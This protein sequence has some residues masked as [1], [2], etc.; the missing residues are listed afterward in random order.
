M[1]KE[2]TPFQFDI[3]DVLKRFRRIARSRI[4]GVTLSLPF[5]SVGVSPK[6]REKQIARELV[7][8][9]KDR[10]V[11]N[12][13]ECCDNCINEALTS[14]Q[15]IRAHLVDK[16]VELSELQ[17]GPLYLLI[18]AM[19]LGIRQFLTFEQRLTQRTVVPPGGA[20]NSDFYRAPEIRQAY[21]D[22]LEIL[23]GHLSRCLGQVA[24]LAGMNAPANGLIPNYQ[25][26]WQTE[27]YRPLKLP[28]R[29]S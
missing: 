18:D 9:L 17:D 29:P 8:R 23:R 6:S 12:A 3:T 25:G 19:L 15:E 11:L 4:G 2:S 20:R 22:G 14:L 21:F 13:R 10:R 16:H 5:I 24:K 7:T 1:R 26:A 28:V 27:V